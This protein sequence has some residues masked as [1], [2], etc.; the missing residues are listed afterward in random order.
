MV[1]NVEVDGEPMDELK[2]APWQNKLLAELKLMGPGANTEA[3]TR[4]AL[5]LPSRAPCLVEC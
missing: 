5:A 3:R 4:F 1:A 2:P